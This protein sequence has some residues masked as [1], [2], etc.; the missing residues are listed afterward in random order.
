MIAVAEL[1]KKERLP[2]NYFAPKAYIQSDYELG[3]IENRQGN[4]LIALPDTLLAALYSSLE[5]EV[6]SSAGLVMFQ[7][8]RWWGKYFYRRFTEEVSTHYDK[9]LAE[10]EMV[11]FLQCIKQCW[12][13]YGWGV[14]GVDFSAYDQ[15]FIVAT[16]NNSAFA[17]VQRDQPSEQ[18][19]CHTEAGLLSAFFSQLTGQDLHCVQ[20]ACE[21]MGAPQNSFVLGL[22]ERVKVA[23]ACLQE[24]Q[25]H[26]A[27]M[28]RLGIGQPAGVEAN[29]D[30]DAVEDFWSTEPEIEAISA[31]SEKTEDVIST[32]A[33]LGTEIE[34]ALENSESEMAP[35][36]EEQPQ[37]EAEML[38]AEMAE[39]QPEDMQSEDML[40]AESLEALEGLAELPDF[41]G[42]D[43]F[44]DPS[45]N[46][47]MIQAESEL[48]L[49]LEGAAE[50]LEP[51]MTPDLGEPVQAEAA[52]LPADLPEAQSEDALSVDSLAALENL[53]EFPDLEG[54]EG[55]D[56]LEALAELDDLAIEMPLTVEAE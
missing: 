54:F 39:V 3:L 10:M 19:V 8:G 47:E 21:S 43:G 22:A 40:S 6:G 9:P 52:A 55:L 34:V 4:R 7:C 48:P 15:G 23:E 11:E 16:V 1:L 33:E 17:E 26:D 18:P 35:E 56:E 32:E 27:I 2:G 5:E 37:V 29:D 49:E 14:L 51:E 41:E 53:S 45:E 50:Q 28:M 12:K 31:A 42:F 46:S 20:T 13:T 30:T 24:K 36:I 38:T 44:S 25:D